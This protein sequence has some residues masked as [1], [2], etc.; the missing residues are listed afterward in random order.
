MSFVLRAERISI[1]I[2]QTHD[3]AVAWTK[4]EKV[5]S[6][7]ESQPGGLSLVN[8]QIQRRTNLT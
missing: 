6:D 7:S 4:L 3:A 5:M 2:I 8:E 1:V